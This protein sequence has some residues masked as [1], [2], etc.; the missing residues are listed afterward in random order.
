MNTNDETIFCVWGALASRMLVAVS[1]RN[2]LPC[3][4]FATDYIDLYRS[5]G[6]GRTRTKSAVNLQLARFHRLSQRFVSIGVHSWLQL[7]WS[8]S[9]SDSG[10]ADQRNHL[11][12]VPAVNAKIF[13]GCNHAVM[14]I[15]LAHPDQTKIGQIGLPVGITFG[16]VRQLRQMIIAIERKR[17]ET[18]R[19]HLQNQPS[20]A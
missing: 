13:V 5:I 19:E 4:V 8:G 6:L 11:A 7:I 12:F 3:S 1:R 9:S 17:K 2:D 16:Q 15:K 18:F 14:R 20:I 10:R